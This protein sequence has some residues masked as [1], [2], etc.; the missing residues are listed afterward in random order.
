MSDYSKITNF[1]SKDSLSLNDPAKYVK[2]SE[3]DAECNAIAA[4]IAT[5]ADTASPTLTTP[6]MSSPTITGTITAAIANFS[7]L[8]TAALGL[9]VSGAAFN[10]R[11]ITDNATAKA[12]TLSGSGANSVTISN[13]ASNPT[14]G[15][16][17]G[18]LQ[19]SSAGN[20]GLIVN[21]SATSD[22]WL[23]AVSP[24]TGNNYAT[25]SAL[26]TAADV[27]FFQSSKGSGNIVFYTGTLT[28][29]QAAILHTASADRYITLT[30]SNGG[31][32]TIGTSAGNLNLSSAVSCLDNLAVGADDALGAGGVGSKGL[33]LSSSSIAVI[34][35][36][37]AP[38]ISAAKGSLYLRSDGTATNNR[39]YVNT[40]GATTWTAVTTV[41]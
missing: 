11:G 30:G 34:A 7:G 37:G 24:V 17:G 14:I 10:S 20:L 27:S 21:A 33:F 36:S 25:L 2:G 31:N 40:D 6:T 22:T 15:T 3:I 29:V 35:G 16:S 38:T 23:Q 13:S 9:T 8:V 39:M 1:L 12:L 41:A 26:G 28:T 5:K 32:P 19:F 18:A 4:S